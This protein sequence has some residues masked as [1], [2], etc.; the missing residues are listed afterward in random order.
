MQDVDKLKQ[1]LISDYGSLNSSLLQ[2]GQH[3]VH[4]EVDQ[5][6]KR[7]SQDFILTAPFSWEMFWWS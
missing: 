1:L 5:Q 4:Q 2:A 3:L 7:G 6:R